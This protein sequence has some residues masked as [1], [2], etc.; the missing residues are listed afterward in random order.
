MATSAEDD[1]PKGGAPDDDDD[2]DEKDA[3]SRK[4][5]AKADRDEDDRED[6]EEEGGD[7]EAEEAKPAAK[8]AAT[9]PKDK[10]SEARPPGGKRPGAA[11]IK[12]ARG[13]PVPAVAKPVKRQGAMAKSMVLFV[14]IIGTL[15]VALW[16]LGKDEGGSGVAQPKWTVGQKVDVEVTLVH[17][18][19]Q[20]LACASADELAGR[21]CGFEAKNKPWSKGDVKDDKLL[22]KPYTTTDRIQFLAA[23]LWSDTGMTK[24]PLPRTRF[25][26]KCKYTVDGKI[27]K[28]GV[29]WAGD[30]PWYDQPGDWYA[31]SL[32]DCVITPQ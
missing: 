23:G 5:A 13:K 19:Q 9:A 25:T 6:D 21:H 16:V 28:P 18:D 8:R 15:G 24:A 4:P 22:L 2:A 3:A 27:K 31:G 29:R 7:A 10:K 1:R 32:S 20:D 26:V 12:A 11:A 17:T 14:L 30:G